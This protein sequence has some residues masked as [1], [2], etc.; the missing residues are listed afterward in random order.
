MVRLVDT[1]CHLDFNRFDADR[2]QVI[3]RAE[4]AWVVR[5]IVP[6]VDVP[7][8]RRVVELAE[9]CPSVYAA[10]GIHPNDVPAAAHAEEVLQDIRELAQSRRVVAIGEIGLDYYWKKTPPEAQHEW[11]RSQLDLAAA[12]KLPVILH[13]R[14]T[15]ED[16]IA[17]LREW[18]AQRLPAELDDRRGV[19]HSFSAT[20]RDAEQVLDLGF[21]LGFTGP[22]TYKKADEMRAV[23]VAVPLD[24]ILVETDAPFL[25]PHP[26]RGDRNEPAFIRHTAAKIAELRG[27]DIEAMAEQ[28]TLNADKLFHLGLATPGV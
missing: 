19:F 27:M 2:D 26:H 4:A 22:V 20:K 13:N 25:A 15:T 24:R 3:K 11:L 9:H 21:Y 5:I 14:E 16:L 17:I 23:A 18:T 6:A 10:V 1:H 28:T 12:L 7:S 8:N